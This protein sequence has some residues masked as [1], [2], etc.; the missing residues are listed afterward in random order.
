MTLLAIDPGIKTGWALIDS[1]GIIL[2][3]GAGQSWPSATLA[4]I[5]LPQVYRPGSSAARPE[6]LITLAVRVG[7][8]KERL[9]VAGA[10]V[11]L[12]H[13]AS[14]KGQL[15]KNT[16][17]RRILRDLSAQ[18]RPGVL[19]GLTGLTPKRAED[20]WDA[21]GLAKWAFGAGKFNVIGRIHGSEKAC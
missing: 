1:A 16:H 21:I 7:Q 17:H 2:S 9:E 6:D 15:D 19:E 8:Y 18:D 13:P 3:C 11:E 20:V 5:E 10:L 14:W 12:V 4:L